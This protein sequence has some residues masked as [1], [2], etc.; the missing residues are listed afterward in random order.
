VQGK[1]GQLCAAVIAGN[2]DPSQTVAIVCDRRLTLAALA[3][4]LIADD[5]RSVVAVVRGAAEVQAALEASQPPVVVADGNWNSSPQI[6]T[7]AW[8]GRI[9]FL[10]DPNAPIPGGRASRPVAAGYLSRT[11]SCEALEVAL[12]SVRQ[13]GRYIDPMLSA[14]LAAAT[15]AAGPEPAQ[16]PLSERELQILAAIAR[17]K[18]SK[19]IAR[20][21]SV[22]PKTICNHVSNIYA[23]LNLNHRGQLVLYA[24][25]MGLTQPAPALTQSL[26]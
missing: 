26:T 12:D 10:L 8:G 13:L 24:A 5:S 2:D 11:A 25:E 3:S 19:E 17:G 1:D 14:K 4:L 9:L 16:S 18:S 20:E 6:D 21:C 22:S 7:S 15:E 23:K